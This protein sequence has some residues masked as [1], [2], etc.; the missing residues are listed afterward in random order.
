MAE[1]LS[2]KSI[3]FVSQE[4]D[5]TF[6][7]A[8]GVS[9][10]TMFHDL[11]NNRE[12]VD[13]HPIFSITGLGEALGEKAELE[14]SHEEYAPLL[15]KHSKAD[16]GLDKV[17]NTSDFT[18][19][20]SIDVE[21]ALALKSDVGHDHIGKSNVGHQ[22]SPVEVGLENIDNTADADKPV[23]NDT[24]TAL[25]QKVDKAD[26]F[27][28]YKHSATSDFNVVAYEP[29]FQEVLQLNMFALL[30]G[31]YEVT[32]G[33]RYSCGTIGRNLFIRWSI[34]GGTTWHDSVAFTV[35]NIL[36]RT[37]FVFRTME[38]FGV[39][40]RTIIVQAAKLGGAGTTILR[41]LDITCERKA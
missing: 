20:I 26:W 21:A 11:M 16:V 37:P 24:Q 2:G 31:K 1:E 35:V 4:V 15:H 33:C 40:D 9:S 14:H 5:I 22:H 27:N 28:F 32:I 41:E 18:K 36:D 6:T 7:V 25:D 13:Q 12:R 8:A 38:T 17:D 19:P 30:T 34:N 39:G 3:E 23:S 29:D 10:G